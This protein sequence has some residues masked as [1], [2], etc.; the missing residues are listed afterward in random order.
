MVAGVIDALVT[1][2]RSPDPGLVTYRLGYIIGPWWVEVICAAV[3]GT[4]AANLW[5][6]LGNGTNG[7]GVSA[8]A[9]GALWGAGLLTDMGRA[10]RT[11]AATS[12]MSIGIA[13]AVIAI[14]RLGY[15]AAARLLAL[16]KRHQ[17]LLWAL[18]SLCVVV[19]SLASS[20]AT[21]DSFGAG[22]GRCDAAAGRADAPNIILITVDSLRADAGTEMNSY[23]LLAERGVE[24]RQHITNAPWTLPSVAS[25][26]TGQALGVHAAGESLSS[27]VLIART[28]LSRNVETIAEALSREGYQTHAVV[29]NPF[30]TGRY[31]V[32]RGF[33]TFDNVTMKGEAL[34]GLSQ[35]TPVRIARAL[36]PRLLPSDR[37]DVVRRDVERWLMNHA[38]AGTP[39]FL[40]IHFLD[41]H[42]PYGDRDGEPTSLTL[43]LLAF[44]DRMDVEE[45]YFAAPGGGSQARDVR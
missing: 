43:D 37:A 26:L 23:R 1:L 34:R 41:P 17:Q 12:V 7:A 13:L 31:G 16:R 35:T 32:D 28:S 2:A 42:A 3:F 15:H 6:R 29:T 44:Q 20:P 39:F 27:R 21:R 4:T 30:L 5:K 8:A 40:W 25:L 9:A 33:C 24:F 45:P 14:A 10:D 19:P 38:V 22:S 11:V 18:G 36:A